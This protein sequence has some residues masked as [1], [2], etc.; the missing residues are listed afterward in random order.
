MARSRASHDLFAT[1]QD[2]QVR[3]HQRM[4]YGALDFAK[5]P[6]QLLLHLCF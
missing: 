2:F 5:T 1:W 3:P 6:V 4:A